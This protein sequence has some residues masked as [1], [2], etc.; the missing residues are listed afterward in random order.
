MGRTHHEL[1]LME[2]PDRA[3]APS[4]RGRWLSLYHR[5]IKIG[6]SLDEHVVPLNGS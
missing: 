1:L 6:Y 3:P 5:G 4:R 2:L